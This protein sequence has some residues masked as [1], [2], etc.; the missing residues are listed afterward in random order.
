MRRKWTSI[1]STLGGVEGQTCKSYT[2][3]TKQE[4]N[5]LLANPSFAKA[6]KIQLV[7]IL[8]EWDDAPRALKRQA[9]LSA[10]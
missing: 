2:V 6:D 1:L 5:A 8:M 7:E 10:V 9:E 3:E 4:F